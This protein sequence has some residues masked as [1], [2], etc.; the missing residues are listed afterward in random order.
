MFRL[1]LVLVINVAVA[2]AVTPV[3][4]VAKMLT[5]LQR[6]VNEEGVA[7]AKTYDSFACFC[8]TTIA[9]KSKS[10]SDGKIEKNSLA[11]RIN[12]DS[13]IREKEDTMIATKLKEI[14][15]LEDAIATAKADRKSERLTYTKN[16]LDLTS[17]L[18]GLESAIRA[19]S[20]AKKGMGFAQLP[21]EAQSALTMAQALLPESR[22][23]KPLTA[24]LA[25]DTVKPN[26]A[27]GFHSDELMKVIGDLQKDFKSK[28]DELSKAA[29]T[30]KADFDK[31][32]QNKGQA[33]TDAQKALDTSK[34]DK[35]KA[36]V[37]IGT[38]SQDLSTTAADLLDDQTYLMEISKKC[39][40]KAVL[41]DKRSQGRAAELTA[42]TTAINLISNLPAEDS[43]VSSSALMQV[44]AHRK[45]AVVLAA[46]AAAAPAKKLSAAAV[47]TQLHGTR[48]QVV[49][50]LSVY[51]SSQ[52]ESLIAA[53]AADPLAKVK[54]L[55]Q[56]L[57][58]RL[59]KQAAEE[60][61]HKG[62]CD[63]EYAMT[64]MKRDKAADGIKETNGLLELGEARRAKL[65]EEIEGLEADIKKLGDT[66]TKMTGIRK[67]DKEDNEKA[68]KDAKEGKQTVEKAID[69]LEKYYKTAA[70]NAASSSSSL[71]QVAAEP[72]TPDAGFDGEY[73]GAQDGSVGVL[74]MLDVIKSDFVRAIK[75]TEQ[76][77]KD[78]QQVFS[79]LE[80]DS[81]VSLATKS[82]SL[83]SRKSA[84][85][86]ADAADTKNRD[87]QKSHQGLLDGSLKEM[88]A[89]DKACQK[90]GST[91]EERKIQRDEEMDAL[92]KAMCILDSGSAG[93]C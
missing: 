52:L 1:A 64:T 3:E 68:I 60:A 62:W 41:W 32:V 85:D 24:F 86:E 8:K 19:M 12:E 23:S 87:S 93:S 71:L 18:T 66:L 43:K 77:E 53:A 33:V 34:N 88:D 70:K 25:Q 83:K 46:A 39:G 11:T 26:D 21:A 47:S 27:Y 17:A 65:G 63:K 22:S 58:E 79:D 67:K 44:K 49:A 5:D 59:L 72:E 16:E 38:A 89:L 10:V 6:Q 9:E 61:S 45:P 81:G 69:V 54:Q 29:V 92:K 15:T 13:V 42:L 50:A 14:K 48:A 91:A 78:A 57:I 76:D 20:A 37:R 4:K 82:E 40:E 51:K 56:E 2:S 80:T 35:A 73:A 7:E 90:G 74:G 55:V 31:L 84:K 36:T 28:K 75:E 30:A